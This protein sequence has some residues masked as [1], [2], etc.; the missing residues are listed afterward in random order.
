MGAGDAREKQSTAM[1]ARNLEHQ[2]RAWPG[3]V[4]ETLCCMARL[5][6]RGRSVDAS[7]LALQVGP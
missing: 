3:A 1:L 6:A 5:P 4:P 7:A 2:H